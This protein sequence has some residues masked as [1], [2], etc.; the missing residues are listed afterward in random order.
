MRKTAAT[1]NLR[2]I[3]GVPEWNELTTNPLAAGYRAPTGKCGRVRPTNP[4]EGGG[5]K[6]RGKWEREGGVEGEKGRRKGG[7]G[8]KNEEKEEVSRKKGEGE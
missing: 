3:Q 4:S 1:V 5:G 6:E 8:E 2:G 7:E